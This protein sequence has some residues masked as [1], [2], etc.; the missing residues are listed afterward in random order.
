MKALRKN[1]NVLVE[2]TDDEFRA[3]TV[4]LNETLMGPLQIDDADWARYV[5]VDKSLLEGILEGLDPVS[6]LQ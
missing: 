2:L 6:N 5:E 1:K 3:L 4:F